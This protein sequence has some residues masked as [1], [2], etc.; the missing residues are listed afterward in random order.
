MIRIF[1][2][3]YSVST[4]EI[5]ETKEILLLLILMIIASWIMFAATTKRLHDL[6]KSGWWQ[7]LGYLFPFAQLFF[8]FY[9]IIWK[10]NDDLN[11]YGQIPDK[12]QNFI[13]ESYLNSE[14]EET[15]LKILLG[16]IFGIIGS[17]IFIV[18]FYGSA[19]IATVIYFKK[20]Y[21]WLGGWGIF[22]AIV[23]NFLG[24]FLFPFISWI[25]DGFSWEFFVLWGIVWIGS[26]IL[27]SRR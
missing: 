25:V 18:L 21:E 27:A 14:K 3:P 24:F 13:D 16:K 12:K 22:L 23:T 15:N 9:L 20:L 7:L 4:P 6:G 17:T 26:G 19:L 11:K 5:L 8:L 10:G 2:D 1:P